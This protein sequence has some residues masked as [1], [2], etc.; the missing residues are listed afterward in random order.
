MWINSLQIPDCFV[1]NLYE[2]VRDGLVILRVCHRIDETSCD[3]SKANHKP[4][5]MFDCNHNC[6]MA[7][8][9]MRKIGVKMIGVGSQDIREGNKKNILAMV[10]QL[11]RQHYLRLI[12]SK[13]DADLLNWVNESC[14]LDTPLA[15]FGDAQFSSGKLLIKLAATIEPRMIN[16][17]LVTEGETEE[18]R[19]MNAKYAISI[20]RKLGAIIFCVWDD[21][22][23]LNK[24]ML[25][26]FVCSL[27][28]LKHNIQ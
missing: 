7:E 28:D 27:Y 2:E 25:L 23:N 5:N 4:K 8:E 19:E 9:A 11:M 14:Q 12:G 24:K 13:T 10:W 16:W 22:P 18:D 1:E 21:I 20:A 6:D 15:N 3:L 17:D 26:I